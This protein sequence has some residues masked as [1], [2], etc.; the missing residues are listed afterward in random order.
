MEDK[1]K[2][3]IRD[4]RDI[5]QEEYS[6]PK[7]HEDRFLAKL[8]E[9]NKEVERKPFNYWRVAAIFIPIC[10]LATYFFLEFQPQSGEGFQNSNKIL[11]SYSPELNEAENHFSF[12]VQQK[13]EEVKALQNPENKYFI[14]KSLKNLD[15]L[16]KDYN[17]LLVDLKESGGNSQVVR[18]IL[19]NLQLQVELMEN[20]LTQIET[21]QELKTNQNETI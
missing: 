8:K 20:V 18:S 17:R 5:M 1:W 14:H 6:L 10:M 19:L 12:I 15:E 11:A 13:V 7:G 2:E 21:I 3:I 9:R 16:Q 4:N